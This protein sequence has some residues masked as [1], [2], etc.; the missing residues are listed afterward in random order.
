VTPREAAADLY[1]Q[2]RQPRTFE[3]DVAFHEVSGYVIETPTA[4]LMGRGVDRFT[5]P[6]CIRCPH[7]IYPRSRQNAWF[8]WVFAGDITE[9]L[10]LAPYWLPDVGWIRRNGRIRWY[11]CDLALKRVWRVAGHRINM[12]P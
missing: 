1:L 9:M 5:D 12:A 3:E 11:P 7:V 8:I 4:F 6:E 10:R 2:Y